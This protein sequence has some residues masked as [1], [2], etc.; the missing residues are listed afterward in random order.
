MN[1][2]KSISF[3]LILF[4]AVGAWAGSESEVAGLE[5]IDVD[6]AAT[7]VEDR[8]GDED[9]VILDVRTPQEFGAGHVEGAINIDFYRADFRELLADL[10]RDK[11]YLVYCRSGSRSGNTMA[12]LEELEFAS[13]YN[14]LGGFNAAS[15][16]L[17]VE[18]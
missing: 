12:I 7:L 10:D 4:V 2:I 6:G 5:N 1:I 17:P 8:A 16:V 14:L 9:F 11:T 3:L 18:R 13:A 15:N